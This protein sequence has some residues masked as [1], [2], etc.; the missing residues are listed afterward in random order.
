M[1][2][3]LILMNQKNRSSDSASADAQPAPAFEDDI[4]VTR[5]Q[6]RRLMEVWSGMEPVLELI[7]TDEVCD[8]ESVYYILKPFVRELGSVLMEIDDNIEAAVHSSREGEPEES[9]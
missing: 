1:R 7:R 3:N 4:Y 5:W 9:P 2:D 8:K 6:Y